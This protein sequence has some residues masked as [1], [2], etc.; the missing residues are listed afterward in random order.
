MIRVISEGAESFIKKAIDLE[1]KN[2][3]VE[4]EEK[5]ASH[6]EAESVIREEYEEVNEERKLMKTLLKG[7]H[8]A[9]RNDDDI[10]WNSELKDGKLASLHLAEEAVQLAAMLQKA[11]ESK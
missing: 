4:Y 5:F 7:M 6:H 2:T 1:L 3:K 11:E 8:L 9:L 10:L